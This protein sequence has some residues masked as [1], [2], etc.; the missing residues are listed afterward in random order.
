M[1]I[2]VPQIHH[3]DSVILCY[4]YLELDEKP[5]FEMHKHNILLNL[6]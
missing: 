5:I 6:S 4:M 1:V 3:L 2:Y